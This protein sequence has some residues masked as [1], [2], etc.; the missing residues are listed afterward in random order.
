MNEKKNENYHLD[1]PQCP[2]QY[3]KRPKKGRILN[4][5]QNENKRIKINKDR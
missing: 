4:I 2:Y 5:E 1:S 3:L